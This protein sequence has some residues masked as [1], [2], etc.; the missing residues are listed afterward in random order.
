MV[1]IA[2]LERV[3]LIDY[4]EKIS[5]IIF[6]HG[7][8][9]RCSFCHNPEL[10]LVDF[11]SNLAVKESELFEY[12]EGRKGKIDAVVITGGEP[13][14]HKDIG[15]LIKKIKDIG[16]LVKLDSNG[17]FPKELKRLISKGL[18]DY[19]AMDVKWPED[20]YVKYSGDIKALE[21]IKKSISIIENCG[22]AHEFRTTVVKG[23][24]EIEDVEE[25]GIEPASFFDGVTSS[26][27]VWKIEGKRP[28]RV[29]I[30]HKYCPFCGKEII[31][32]EL[33]QSQGE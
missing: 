15:K 26:F 31:K 20:S 33:K 13:L 22:I 1:K 28:K 2:G 9:L 23:I 24:H 4:P 17:F 5:A 32:K 30:L 27:L 3:S 19:I 29:Y 8:N 25:I 6:T 12:L 21:K 14:L 10:V 7:C 18:I 16:Y 11:D